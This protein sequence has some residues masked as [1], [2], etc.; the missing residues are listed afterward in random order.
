MI[1]FIDDSGDPGFK[2]EKGSS[3]VFV[4]TL[5]IFDDNLEAEKTAVEIKKLKR[6]LKFP[7]NV[8]FKFHQ[9]SIR[10]K[11]KF[12]QRVSPFKFRIRAIVVQKENIRSPFLKDN[13]E[14]FFNY[15]VMQVLRNNQKV[16]KNAKLKFDKRGEKKIRDN[17]R[18]YLSREL[19]NRSSHIFKDLKFV[20][21]KENVLIQLADM[22][23]GTIADYYKNN[24]K[25]LIKII[26]KQN[27]DIWDF[28]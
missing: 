13:K 12:L 16:I 17:L 21:S 24:N 1:V 19:G 2:I 20:D 3:K 28:K 6:D 7:D 14:S 8:E 11:R 18:A 23:A 22:T 26:K 10:V 25:S 15:I 27:E 9:S 5:V 4:I